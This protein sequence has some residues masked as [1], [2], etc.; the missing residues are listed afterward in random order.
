MDVDAT[1]EQLRIE[2]G[3]DRYE[4]CVATG[5]A[6]TQPEAVR[7]ARGRIAALRATPGGVE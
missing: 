4:A 5:E 1:A 7:F 2:M 3:S 6:M